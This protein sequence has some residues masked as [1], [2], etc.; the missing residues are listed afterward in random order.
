MTKKTLGFRGN[1][2]D[3]NFGNVSAGTDLRAVRREQGGRC[4]NFRICP[5]TPVP[6]PSPLHRR[7]PPFPRWTGGV[8]WIVSRESWPAP[9]GPRQGRPPGGPLEWPVNGGP[10]LAFQAFHGRFHAPTIRRTVA[11]RHGR[12]KRPPQKKREAHSAWPQAKRSLP[13]SRHARR[14]FGDFI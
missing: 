6:I 11:E 10:W 14:L 12:A 7:F 9:A 3:E 8:V 5:N 2:P 4:F 13:Y 1:A